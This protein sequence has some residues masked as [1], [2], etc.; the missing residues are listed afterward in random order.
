MTTRKATPQDAEILMD[1]YRNHLTN[2]AQNQPQSMEAW[3]EK[4]AKF[5]ANPM[6]NIFV[7]E[8]EGR[9]VSAVTLVIIENLTNN[10]RP[11]AIIENVVTHTH[12]R[13]KGYASALMRKASDTAENLNCYKIML[14]T[15]SKK[16]STLAFYENC[17][18]KRKEKT[19]FIKRF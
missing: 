10:M 3:R 4:I 14:L 5:E 17:G 2:F 9:V 13:G 11:Y 18:F 12:F 7:G 1:L 16:E 8:V 15:G 19:G 6:Y